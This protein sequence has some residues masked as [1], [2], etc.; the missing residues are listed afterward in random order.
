M[1]PCAAGPETVMELRFPARPDLMADVRRLLRN[2]AAGCGLDE[3]EIEDTVLAIAEAC[4]NVMRHG[5]GNGTRGDIVVSLSRGGDGIVVRIADFAPAVNPARLRAR[6]LTEVRPGGL[7]IHFI[8]EL[9]DSAEFLP[10]PGGVGN[11]LTMTRK[12]GVSA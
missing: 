4:Q 5:Y 8:T 9:M 11:V 10:G 12:T 3:A 7:G 6:D 2:G 1:T